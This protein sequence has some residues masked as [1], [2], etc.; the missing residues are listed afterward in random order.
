MATRAAHGVHAQLLPFEDTYSRHGETAA[1]D[2]LHGIKAA[3]S[4]EPKQLL[5]LRA[6]R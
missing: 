4:L 1:S 2:T 6:T 3:G 5:L